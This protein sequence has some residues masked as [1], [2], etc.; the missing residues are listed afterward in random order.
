MLRAQLRTDAQPGRDAH[1]LAHLEDKGK[2]LQLLQHQH[3]ARIVELR[4]E[5]HGLDVCLV[6][7]TVAD[8]KTVR[9][10]LLKQTRGEQELRLGARFQ[11]EVGG[12][13]VVHHRLQK[14]TVV[15][16]LHRK[17]ALVVLRKANGLDGAGEGILDCLQ[18]VTHDLRKS[19]RDWERNVLPRK[20]LHQFEHIDRWRT[21]LSPRGDDQV[22]L[23]V[24][25]EVRLPPPIDPIQGLR[26]VHSPRLRFFI[27]C[28]MHPDRHLDQDLLVV[29][30]LLRP[31]LR[32]RATRW[33]HIHLLV[34]S[35]P[36]F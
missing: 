20:V 2:L 12:L 21:F 22:A 33:R 26:V 36:C 35:F 11:A 25:V 24:E 17:H 28:H 16:A 9:A 14:P 19:E 29:L 4:G 27:F 1:P 32:R 23:L 15:V 13:A 10:G 34:L 18:P 6:L 3:D 7:V 30:P 8:E 31:L 5:Q